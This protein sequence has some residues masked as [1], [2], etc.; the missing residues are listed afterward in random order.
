MLPR[1]E[2]T[3]AITKPLQAITEDPFLTKIAQFTIVVLYIKC[4]FGKRSEESRFSSPLFCK[5]HGGL[6]ALLS[7]LSIFCPLNNCHSYPFKIRLFRGSINLIVEN[8]YL[9]K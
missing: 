3:N 8:F 1:N 9:N 4:N 7:G 5:E 6:R 2:Q